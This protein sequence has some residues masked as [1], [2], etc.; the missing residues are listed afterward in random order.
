MIQNNLSLNKKIVNNYT[1]IIF[2]MQY[3]LQEWW[4]RVVNRDLNINDLVHRIIDSMC[5]VS[6]STDPM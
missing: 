5:S 2:E 3:N 4:D 6:I 1:T